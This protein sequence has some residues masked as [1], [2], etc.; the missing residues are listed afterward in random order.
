MMMKSMGR[1]VYLRE[2]C[3][4]LDSLVGEFTLS[5]FPMP[6]GKENTTTLLD[7]DDDDDGWKE[8]EKTATVMIM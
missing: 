1:S 7:D 6:V 3:I 8:R 4:S 2:T 5:I